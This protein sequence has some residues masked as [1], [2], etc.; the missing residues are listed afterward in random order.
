MRRRV[1]SSPRSRRPAPTSPSGEVPPAPPRHQSSSTTISSAS[2][3]EEPS[4]CEAVLEPLSSS[5]PSLSLMNMRH[6]PM[7]ASTARHH[8]RQQSIDLQQSCKSSSSTS[9]SSASTSEDVDS[10]AS[11]SASATSVLSPA[12]MTYFPSPL[13]RKVSLADMSL[14]DYSFLFAPDQQHRRTS[15]LHLRAAFD[16]AM[17]G[18]DSLVVAVVA[19]RQSQNPTS[20]TSALSR[21][22]YGSDY[23]S[24]QDN[25]QGDSERF[26]LDAIEADYRV[27]IGYFG[28]D[29]RRNNRRG[30]DLA[31]FQSKKK[32]TKKARAAAAAAAH[33]K[34]RKQTSTGSRITTAD[35]S[36]R[37]IPPPPPTSPEGAS[38]S[39]PPRHTLPR[40]H[41]PTIPIK[42][43][44]KLFS[45]RGKE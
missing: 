38:S 10:D 20:R 43:L 16:S 12:I 7:T 18:R 5:P 19:R 32:K 41:I 15:A 9:S 31:Q 13:P 35:D 34:K 40:P 1:R 14:S 44:G 42:T 23:F 39:S 27:P 25:A 21:G 24:L 4:N 8:N 22:S 3:I 33:P 45:K 29:P 17:F 11:A 28:N 6:T 26:T 36:G 2:S 37:S 30:S